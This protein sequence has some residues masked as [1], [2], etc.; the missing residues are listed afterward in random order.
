M[1]VA[2]KSCPPCKPKCLI[3][4]YN[5]CTG[6]DLSVGNCLHEIAHPSPQAHVA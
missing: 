1:C 3:K 4:V 6:V 2:T 5:A